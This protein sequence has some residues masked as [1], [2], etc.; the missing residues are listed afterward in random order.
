[1]ALIDPVSRDYQVASL[2]QPIVMSL[3]DAARLRL[4]TRRGSYWRDPTLGSRFYLIQK[5]VPQALTLANQY[6]IE[7]LQPLQDD[8]RVTSI[9]AS[10]GW[11]NESEIQVLI[12]MTLPDGSTLTI[13]NFFVK[14]SG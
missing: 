12:T 7:A 2:N 14:V 4:E 1:M 13:D 11:V 3:E 5:A 8:G 6:A 9:T 10:S